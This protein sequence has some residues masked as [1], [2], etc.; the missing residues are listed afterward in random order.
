MERKCVRRKLERFCVW[1]EKRLKLMSMDEGE[2]ESR[3]G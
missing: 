3:L 1:N 2:G